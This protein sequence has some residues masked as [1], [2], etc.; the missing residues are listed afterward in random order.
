MRAPAKLTIQVPEFLTLRETAAKLGVSRE[1]VRRLIDDKMLA[2]AKIRRSIRVDADSVR[3]FL[4]DEAE[5]A[6]A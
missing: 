6:A 4:A 3:E 1:T 2:A 5:Q